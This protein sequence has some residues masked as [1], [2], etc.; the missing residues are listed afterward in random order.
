MKRLAVALAFCLATPAAAAVAVGSKAFP[1][2]Y[3]LAEMMAQAIEAEGLVVERRFGFEGTLVCFEALRRGE[4]QVYPEYTGTLREVI[5]GGRPLEALSESGVA[6]LPAF[7]FS[8]SYGLAVRRD[9]AERLDLQSISDLAGAPGLRIALSHEFRERPDGWPGLKRR[10]GLTAVPG[11]IE[12]GLA[13]RALAQ[14]RID[15]T[16]VYTTD[17]DIERHGLVVL[18]D[19]RQYFPDYRAVPLAAPALPPAAR[20]AIERLAGRIDA[21]RMRKLNARVVV[22]GLTFAVVAH[23][24]LVAEG[25]AAGDA[26]RADRA[27]RLLRNTL[28]HLKLTGIALLAACLAGLAT[29]VLVF[30]SA[31]ATRV[32]LYVAGLMQTVPSIALLALMIPLLGVGQTPAIVALFLYA[33]LP[34]VSST[35]TALR[36]VDPVLLRVSE[37]MGMTRWQQARLVRVPLAVPYVLAGLKTAAVISIGTATLAAFIGA[38]GLGEPIVTGLALN[39]PGLILEGALPA[40]G[41]AVATEIAFELAERRLIPAHLRARRS[42]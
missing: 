10:Y 23:D 18:A 36:S 11:G 42:S 40:A 37:A 26:P 2:S 41:L 7:G 21:E 20:A 3:L 30:R 35:V 39:D 25:L 32:V 9:T 6:M 27:G 24:F 28:V 12:H 15:V 33:L 8:N 17:G 31:T 22:E 38:G 5:L 34:I 16:D 19:D 29:S 13:Y 14:G 1:E 4:I